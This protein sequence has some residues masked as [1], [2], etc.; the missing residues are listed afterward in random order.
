M[1]VLSA[2]LPSKLFASQPSFLPSSF[3]HSHSQEAPSL[4]CFSS[5]LAFL[6]LPHVLPLAPQV[7]ESH[8]SSKA[9]T[10]GTAKALV[11]SFGKLLGK[12]YNVEDVIRMI[13]DR[14][15]QVGMKGGRG[16]REERCA[17]GFQKGATC[18]KLVLSP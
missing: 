11:G 4:P 13:R 9:D 6:P 17:W 14:E 16:R 10:S 3:S 18:P 7:V 2:S 15:G 1:Y 8:Q 5:H 12:A